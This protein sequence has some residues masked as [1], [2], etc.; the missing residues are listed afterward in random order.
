VNSNWSPPTLETPRLLLRP[1][2]DADAPALF[3]ACSN[4]RLTEHTVFDTH[5]SIEETRN[6]LATYARLKYA[7]G[8]PDPLGIAFRDRPDE[9]I[10]CAGAH[11]RTQQDSC[12]EFGYWV[13]EE[14]WGRGIATEAAGALVR[15]VF[16]AFPVE[17]LQARVFTGN[18]ASCR[19]LEKL[20]FTREGVLRSGAFVKGRFR[21]VILFALLR[22]DPRR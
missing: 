17:R 2:T 5:R 19:V 21:D 8:E 11:W 20:G 3:A 13:A 7:T 6:F 1:V 9:V 16:D 15:H 18:D 4:P 10:G 14:H 12:L 22:G